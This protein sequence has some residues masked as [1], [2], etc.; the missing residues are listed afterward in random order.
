MFRRTCGVLA[1]TLLVSVGLIPPSPAGA[2][3]IGNSRITEPEAEP[4]PASG[5]GQYVPLTSPAR[6]LDTG[7]AVGVPTSTPVPAQGTVTSKLVGRG[8]VPAAGVSA[9]VANIIV[10]APTATGALPVWPAGGSR[11]GVSTLLF[12]AGDPWASASSLI[13]LNANG[14][15]SFANL[16]A[17]T[18]RI[19]VDVVGF[20]TDDSVTAPGSRFVPVSQARIVDTRNAVGVGTRTPVPANGTIT[21]AA[22]SKG[23]LPAAA[24]I[25][26]VVLNI[27]AVTPTASGYWTAFAG[28]T[29]RPG[30]GS[31]YFIGG[32]SKTNSVVTRLS[33][34]GRLAVFNGSGGTS[35]FL[36]DVAGYYTP[37]LSTK[38]ASRRVT[39][40]TP[41]RALDSGS[42][43]VA[44]G[45]SATVKVTGKG[46]VPST[47]VTG[48][49]LHIIGSGAGTS[50]ELVT[51]PAGAARPSGV[52]DVIYP[53]SRYTFNLVWVRLD[54]TGSALIHNGTNSPIRII[55]DVQAYMRA[56]ERPGSPTAVSASPGDGSA[57]V[58]WSAPESTG[59]LPLSG[60]E[61]ITAPGGI[62]STVSGTSAAI[63]GLTNDIE[64]TFTV[65]SRNV[66]G[67]SASSAPS[68]PV[69]PLAPKPPGK[70]LITA[71]TPR[72]REALVTWA[73]PPTGPKSV[74]SYR[75]EAQPGGASILVS[76]DRLEATLGGL[77]NDQ[78]YTLVVT[79]INQAGQQASDPSVAVIPTT[80]MPPLPPIISRATP[81]NGRIDLQWLPAADGG[82][83]LLGYSVEVQ[84]GGTRVEIAADTTLASIGS[85]SNG[86]EYT[87]RL[88]ARNRVG[89][90]EVQE[91]SAVP[92]AIR[93]PGAPT[94]VRAV[95]TGNGEISVQWEPPADSGTSPLS[96][97]VVELSP[98]G[99][100]VPSSGTSAIVSD[101]DPTVGYSVV[102]KAASA[103]GTG[104]GSDATPSIKPALSFAS[105]PKVLSVAAIAAL[106]HAHQDG[107][108]SF[109][110][111]PADVSALQVG[112]LIV[113]PDNPKTPRGMLARV[114]RVERQVGLTIVSTAAAAVDD[115]LSTSEMSAHLVPR[116]DD[117]V[118]FVPGQANVRLRESTLRGRT[119]RSGAKRSVSTNGGPSIGLEDGAFA[120]EFSTKVDNKSF[121]VSMSVEP[122][123]K[124]DW[125]I[126]GGNA[127]TVTE[128]TNLIKLESSLKIDGAGFKVEQKLK[129]GKVKFKCIRLMIGPVPVVICPELEL[130]WNTELSGKLGTA[131]KYRYA[132]EV[133]SRVETNNDNISAT[134]INRVAGDNGV[135]VT[136]Y[137]SVSLRTGPAARLTLWFYQLTG[138][139]VRVEL[140]TEMSADTFGN[141]WWKVDLGVTVGVG[142]HGKLL[143]WAFNFKKDDLLTFN[144]TVAQAD[145]SFAGL[146]VEA[147]PDQLQ[148][149][150]PY[151]FE[152]RVQGYPT[153]EP[154]WR[155]VGGVGS[156]DAAGL[157]SSTDVG[158][159]TLEATVPGGV[160]RP[161]LSTLIAVHVGPGR[162]AAP[163]I[164]SAVPAPLGATV[165]W[166]GG[167]DNG[168]PISGFA[169]RTV[170]DTGVRYVPA[171]VTSLRLHELAAGESYVVLVHAINSVGTGPGSRPSTELV[172]LE[173]VVRIG[174]ETN[175]SVTADGLTDNS[176]TAGQDW[177]VQ[178]SRSARYAFFSVA[179]SSILAPSEVYRPGDDSRYLVR[180]DLETGAIDLAS[181][182]VDGLTPSRVFGFDSNAD[183]TVVAFWEPS[184]RKIL[185]HNMTARRTWIA[186][187]R[188][189]GL[190]DLFISDAGDQVFFGVA[191][192]PGS[193]DIN[194]YKA[195]SS[196]EQLIVSAE[197]GAFDVSGDATK[198]TY[199]VTNFDADP[200]L[201]ASTA[202]Q[203]Q[204]SSGTRSLVPVGTSIRG[205]QAPQLSRTGTAYA[206]SAQMRGT[207]LNGQYWGGVAKSFAAG[208]IESA[209]LF[210]I[211][212]DCCSTGPDLGPWITDLSDDGGVVT[213]ISLLSEEVKLKRGYYRSVTTGEMTMVPGTTGEYN[214]LTPVVSGDGRVVAWVRSCPAGCAG[215]V[216]ALRVG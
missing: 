106:R 81:L 114:S 86:T 195:T 140:F 148:L 156:V 48:A 189:A 117:V 50:G 115:V 154:T 30:L 209:D 188:G 10:G 181:R 175:I 155:H 55:A 157:F 186:S 121:A 56:P 137:A 83:T 119:L 201:W 42:T 84:P 90:S 207:G 134:G 24:D 180:K 80:G 72:D 179:A 78:A 70:P 129:L 79:A 68:E 66:A 71:V 92:V 27:T 8:G 147:Y 124:T 150:S 210:G 67:Y 17:G 91:V 88:T 35:H 74:T 194:I 15:A 47:G 12:N 33:A 197:N 110:N 73:A 203:V 46:G 187:D 54:A 87:L 103:A 166:Q 82:S 200:S 108:L 40:V 174:P 14:E 161:P 65:R 99:R 25:T 138:P 4:G 216:L 171:N 21:V 36:V 59:D 125:H 111:P 51:S 122:K 162:P 185:V 23:G 112:A 164:V 178:L 177:G 215:K 102:V 192:P 109:E 145:G 77:D 98:G 212:S 158:D 183:G 19:Y 44:S 38:A 204:L 6:L 96:G 49:A 104:V 170:P 58:V 76:G 85:L 182:G 28:G 146:L 149:G 29:T 120:V 214:D 34:D 211:R 153:A 202:W 113:V 193:M 22:A 52:S 159:A 167:A 39:A 199:H 31:G 61:V 63:T 69:R 127:R 94:G 132:R 172:A 213:L 3:M 196:G 95:S 43:L 37:A 131:L 1:L 141:P 126:G 5:A 163:T 18:V 208:P 139:S 152:A 123:V 151:Q 116:D 118:E 136:P 176:G 101:L 97:Y 143:K 7:A 16:S 169:V 9:L 173:G 190:T 206:T 53:A 198:L 13:R 60:Y 64:Y 100:S 165:A 191:P 11:P 2:G 107:T 144:E 75:V 20:F 26:A 62:R 57:T 133:G 93:P 205:S 128:Q 32:R 160:G 41:F 45:G 89:A 130:E 135:H 168:A 105:T 184:S 142:W